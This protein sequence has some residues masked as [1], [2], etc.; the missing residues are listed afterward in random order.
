MSKAIW[1]K[2]E[3]VAA[4]GGTA[5]GDWPET[6]AGVS[7]DSRT[8]AKDEIYVALK[9]VSLDG[10]TFTADALKKSAGIAVVSEIPQGLDKNT[11]LLVVKDTL[12]ALE[13][14][15]QAA[16]KRSRAKII[17]ITGSVGKTGT[18]EML[19]AALTALDK[20]HVH[21]SLKSHNNHWGVPLSLANL[22]QDAAFGVFEM[23]MNHSGEIA[24]LTRQVRP[25]LAI[26]TTIQPVHIEYLKTVEAIADAKAEIF[27]GMDSDGIVILNRDNE[28]HQRLA[29]AARMKGISNIFFFGEEETADAEL[30]DFSL[31]S[32]GSHVT[33]RIMADTLKYKLAVP[34]HHIVINSL[35]VLLAV[36]CLGQD[37]A[38]AAKALESFEPLAGRGM[39]SEV[40]LAPGQLPVTVIDESYNASPASMDAAIRVLGMN[41]PKG[42][43]R[44]IAILGDMLE[45][46]PQGPILHASLAAPVSE[47]SVDLVLTCGPLSEALH[48]VIPQAIKGPHFAD[49]RALA[50]EIA[51]FV[52]P[53]DVVLIK[54][55]HGSQM[56]Y[57]VR[58]LHD[59]QSGGAFPRKEER[60]NAV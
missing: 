30:S 44:R 13:D 54:G 22:P 58:A 38:A 24:A 49:S 32:S 14:I 31:R 6:I 34:G 4:T 7:I 59:L 5:Q 46:G 36:K 57:I 42:K 48:Q 51:K 20:G 39:R 11:P 50:A 26:I 3:L 35:A 15:G 55:S 9:G 28:H 60:F 8:I 47:A 27:E 18:K 23:G 1:T 37:A 19:A 52:Q 53:G 29:T 10:H 43:G 40:V 25:D 16:R 45:L 41:A 2:K 12:K 56:S 33:A 21:A 17:G